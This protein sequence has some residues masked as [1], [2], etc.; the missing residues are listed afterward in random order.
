[1][2]YEGNLLHSAFQSLVLGSESPQD[3]LHAICDMLL[4]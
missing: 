3:F 4:W 1:M 2:W